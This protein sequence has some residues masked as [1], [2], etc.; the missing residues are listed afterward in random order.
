MS[1]SNNSNNKRRNYF[2][3]KNNKNKNINERHNSSSNSTNYQRLIS[4]NSKSESQ[5][6][7][8]QSEPIILKYVTG[9]ETNLLPWLERTGTILLARYGNTADFFSTGVPYEPKTPAVKKFDSTNDP[10]GLKKKIL[11]TKWV[12]YVKELT[13]IKA[14]NP[15]IWGDMEIYMSKESLDAVKAKPEYAEYKSEYKVSEYLQL[16]KQIHRTEPAVKSTADA[17]ADA[18]EEFHSIKQASNESLIDY[19]NR[20]I[21]A[22]ERVETADKSKKP[23]AVEVARK[24]TRS[25]DLN[26]Y[27]DLVRTCRD[28]ETKYE[29]TLS[30][31]HNQAS[32]QLVFSKGKLVSCESSKKTGEN[33]AGATTISGLSKKEYKIVMNLRKEQQ[34]SSEQPPADQKQKGKKRAS[35][36][37]LAAAATE[38]KKQKKNQNKYSSNQNSDGPACTICSRTN[39]TTENCYY[40]KGCQEMVNEK[41]NQRQQQFNSNSSGYQPHYQSNFGYVPAPQA[42]S[43]RQVSYGKQSNSNENTSDVHYGYVPRGTFQR[44]FNQS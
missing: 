13:K 38:N 40:L 28:D 17:V 21:A 5:N 14:E 31:A 25:L 44:S 7:T 36:D 37:N 15:K 22:V 27:A 19:K 35:E 9:G 23:T 4:N 29:K 30:G 3:R 16:I 18:L 42:L 2:N 11:E 34:S 24:F 1:E 26:R 10:S 43:G 20:L 12:E 8:P 32:S 6:F 39:H 41:R 33:I